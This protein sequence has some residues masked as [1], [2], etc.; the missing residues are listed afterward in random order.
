MVVVVVHGG[1]SGDCADG[2]SVD[3][4]LGCGDNGHPGL[5]KTGIRN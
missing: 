3:S 2:S 1:S 4:A 5:F